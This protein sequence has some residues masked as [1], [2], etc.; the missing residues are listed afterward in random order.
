M[1]YAKKILIILVCSVALLV[2]TQVADASENFATALHTSYT[3]QV[4]GSTTIEYQFK[5]TNRTPTYT[6]T[7]QAL[8]LNSTHL[9]NIKANDATGTTI[10]TEVITTDNQTNIVVLFSEP[11]V[12]QGK[13]Q[14]FT[15]SYQDDTAAIVS[16]KV[17]EVYVPKLA[18]SDQY[19][20]YSVTVTTP[21]LFGTP[22]LVNPKPSTIRANDTSFVS[23]FSDRPDKGIIAI[24][25]TQQIYEIDLLYQLQNTT[26]SRG[27]AQI[28]LP[29]DTS[30]QRVHYTSLT[31]QP[32]SIDRDADG[33]W[34]ATYTLAAGT[35]LNVTTSLLVELSLEPYRD[36]LVPQPSEKLTQALEYWD[37]PSKLGQETAAQYTSSEAI[38][39][40]LVKNF[41]YNYDRLEDTIV[42]LGADTA[43]AQPDQVLCQ[44]YTD[45]FV[46][47][48]RAHG[49][50]ARK[51]T[52]YAYTEN[53]KLRPLSYVQDTLHAWPDYYDAEKGIWLQA[54][55]TWGSTTG[56]VDYFTQFDL[57]HI[58]FAI[59]GH[60][61]TTPYPAGSYTTQTNTENV[62]VKFGSQFPKQNGTLTFAFTS[63]NVMNIQIPIFQ[64]LVVHNQ[65]GQAVY[66]TSVVISHPGHVQT[67]QTIDIPFVL[68]FQTV[69]KPV[70]V[71]V[72]SGVLPQPVTLT[73]QYD[74]QTH[75][76]TVW[77]FPHY[78]EWLGQPKTI[79]GLGVGSFIA[80]FGAWGL[81]VF[82]RRRRGP[83]RR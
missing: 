2:S 71:W 31:P 57:N 43:L 68:P 78:W 33:N 82:V 45:A 52:G 20:T 17:L 46:A 58:V 28:A 44:E 62:K 56:G 54:D 3:V 67:P 72:Q 12:G 81:L 13:T 74:N 15:I 11:A 69:S 16:G 37:L 25:G 53:N 38:Y 26:G 27:I 36:Y 24:F 29:P 73:V 83:L 10:P 30:F 1:L 49:I 59:N 14:V 64:K 39:N 41:E 18:Q 65:T 35:E 19:D 75:S 77:A 70:P 66:N 48:A 80:T 6:I 50:P 60:S 9:K 79:A 23:T 42:R 8:S 7:K 34:L 47:L 32:L 40:Y 4:D 55:P 21:S 61:S 5:V 22:A 51:L 76:F 63:L